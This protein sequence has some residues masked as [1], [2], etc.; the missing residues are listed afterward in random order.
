ML[1][2]PDALYKF[3]F[4]LISSCTETLSS[5]NINKIIFKATFEEGLHGE[6]AATAM[7]CINWY[8]PANTPRFWQEC[9]TLGPCFCHSRFHPSLY[10]WSS[11][12][13][14]LFATPKPSFAKMKKTDLQ[15]TLITAQSFTIMTYASS[16]EF[17]KLR[18]YV[19]YTLNV[20]T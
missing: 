20:I 19:T 15:T 16:M 6:N 2:Q 7:E 12:L 1:P 14:C 4:R 10:T 18:N 17:A 8:I 11:L 5:T 13:C 9:R 3:Y